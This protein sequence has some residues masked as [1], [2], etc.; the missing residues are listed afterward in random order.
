MINVFNGN[1]WALR[2]LSRQDKYCHFSMKATKNTAK[3]YDHEE[4][5]VTL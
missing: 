3:Q 4:D 5:N 2:L 1:Q